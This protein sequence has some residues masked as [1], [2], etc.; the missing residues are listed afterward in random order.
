MH[1]RNDKKKEISDT[2]MK[3]EKRNNKRRIKA[4]EKSRMYGVKI[5]H[6]SWP[7]L[8]YDMPSFLFNTSALACS[9]LFCRFFSSRNS[10]PHCTSMARLISRRCVGLFFVRSWGRRSNVRFSDNEHAAFGPKAEALRLDIV[11]WVSV[12]WGT[13]MVTKFRAPLQHFIFQSTALCDSSSSHLC[14]LQIFSEQQNSQNTLPYALWAQYFGQAALRP[15][16][17]PQYKQRSFLPF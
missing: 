5:L 2:K 16:G 17:L 9:S 6:H 8:L 3:T 11:R 15:W 4:N 14:M 12:M 10:F 13:V 7:C 1:K